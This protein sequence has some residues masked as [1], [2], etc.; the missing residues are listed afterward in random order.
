MAK[1]KNRGVVDEKLFVTGFYCGTEITDA[2]KTDTGTAIIEAF[3]TSFVSFEYELNFPETPTEIWARLDWYIGDLSNA[4]TIGFSTNLGQKFLWFDV[5]SRY[6][7]YINDG[8]VGDTFDI[9]AAWGCVEGAINKIVVHVD[10]TGDAFELYLDD[11]LIYSGSNVGFTDNV[12]SIEINTD[13]YASNEN[14]VSNIILADYDCSQE[15]L[16]G[17][18]VVLHADAVRNIQRSIIVHA[19][20][21]R[22]IPYMITNWTNSGTQSITLTLAEKTLSDTFRLVARSAMSI[23]STIEGQILDFPFRFKIES[24]SFSGILRTF[25]GMYDVDALLYAPI[26]Y[27]ISNAEKS[28]YR[29]KITNETYG[30]AGVVTGATAQT[31]AQKCCAGIGKTAVC[32]FD[33][34]YPTSA[35]S[36][37][38]TN[39][40]SVLTGVFA[41]TSQVPR[42]QINV[43]IRGDNVYFLQRGKEASVIDLDDFPHTTPMYEQSIVRTMW[44][45][46]ADFVNNNGGFSSADN[47]GDW[48]I[49]SISNPN[50]NQGGHGST[51]PEVTTGADGLVERTVEHVDNAEGELVITTDY[52]YT[53]TGR[54]KFLT[55]EITTTRQNGEVIESRTID[56]Y[57]LENGQRYSVGRDADGNTS[58]GLGTYP[59]ADSMNKY[60][61]EVWQL[62]RGGHWV[63]N[64]GDTMQDSNAFP[65]N[66]RDTVA[67][68]YNELRWMNRKTMERVSLQVIGTVENGESQ[69]VTHIFDFDT[70]YTLDGAEYFLVSNTV[71]WTPREFVQSLQL[72]RWR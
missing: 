38:V 7:K 45:R 70:R 56:H 40:Q 34:F 58:S 15:T 33:D 37:T 2:S 23:S 6:I 27:T 20:A 32:N 22:N 17:F 52:E 43:F 53:D 24:I 57:P 8:G 62:T 46:E 61:D 18:D 3:Y 48:Y 42:R 5:D 63:T 29:A 19:D 41:W 30:T 10:V 25:G 60:A 28:T 21:V 66:D 65:V 11:A 12:D 50:I 16:A 67:D 13:R 72:V 64:N 14:A 4:G 26:K 36:E 9:G 59:Y 51:P 49:Q 1:Y 47:W 39:Y 55:R 54:S 69:D 71:S 35:Q 44:A 31:I 68:I